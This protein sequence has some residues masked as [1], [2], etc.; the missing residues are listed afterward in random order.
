MGSFGSLIFGHISDNRAA[1]RIEQGAA[2][3]AFARYARG[4]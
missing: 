2:L 4:F 1:P 3:E